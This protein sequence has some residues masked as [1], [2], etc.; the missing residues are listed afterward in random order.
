MDKVLIAAD[1]NQLLQFVAFYV[2]LGI[3]FQQEKAVFLLSK[4]YT[5]I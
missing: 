4:I 1:D 5:N 2:Q 3:K